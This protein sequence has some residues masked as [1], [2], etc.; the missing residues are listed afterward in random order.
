M[1]EARKYFDSTLG[2]L[3]LTKEKILE[4][5]LAALKSSLKEIDH[6][7]SIHESFPTVKIKISATAGAI[8]ATANQEAHFE[9]GILSILLERK[10]LILE[11]IG[12]IENKNAISSIIDL[13]NQIND[14][15]LKSKLDQELKDLKTRS[16]IVHIE[17][18]NIEQ[19]QIE[20]KIRAEE[21]AFQMQLTLIQN[22]KEYLK[23]FLE[24]QSMA[25]LVGAILL[26]LITFA[27]IIAVFF[28]GQTTEILNNALLVL[29][30]Y[31]FGQA[32]NKPTQT[33]G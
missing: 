23:M 11:R 4:K 1:D 31:F 20:E 9:I 33:Q 13:I 7:I 32:V 24:K 6:L 2:P 26:I 10:K 15:E 21:R 18:K 17:A 22:K 27:L 3:E 19:L 25:T 28:K 8:I 29:L 5:D 12:L 30:G 16:E 14:T